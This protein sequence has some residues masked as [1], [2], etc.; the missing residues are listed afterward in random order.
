MRIRRADT[1]DAAVLFVLNELFNGIG[2]TTKERIEQSLQSNSRELVLV[3]DTTA[4]IVG[5]C[6]AQHLRSMCYDE[7]YVEITELFVQEESRRQG[8]A[9]ALL[10]QVEDMF[11]EQGVKSFQLF[12]GRDNT[13]AQSLYE[14]VGYKRSEERM[15]RKRT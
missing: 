1:S 8:I 11:V 3:A 5:F 7:D 6:C 9:K 2:C 10:S 14:A 13:A 15:Y 12:T 4:G